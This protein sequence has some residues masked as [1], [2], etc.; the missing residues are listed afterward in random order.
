MDYTAKQREYIRLNILPRQRQ[1]SAAQNK[2]VDGPDPTEEELEEF[3]LV[4]EEYGLN[5]IRRQIYASRRDGK[6]VIAPT[7]DGL[8]WLAAQGGEWGGQD[9]PR[10]GPVDNR[11]IPECCEVTVYRKG[12][13]H[14]TTAVLYWSEYA[15]EKPTI[16]Q[17]SM[18]RIM[19][20]KA[21]ES[22]ALRRM[23]PEAL[24]GLVSME[25]MGGQDPGDDLSTPPWEMDGSEPT[26]VR[27]PELP[28]VNRQQAQAAAAGQTG[29]KPGL[30]TAPAG[31]ASGSRTGET[32]PPSGSQ[33]TQAGSS[34]DEG[35]QGATTPS[36]PSQPP[37]NALWVFQDEKGDLDALSK[38][39]KVQVVEIKRSDG[40]MATIEVTANGRKTS[41]A[42]GPRQSGRLMVLQPG[43]DLWIRVKKGE[44]GTSIGA[45]HVPGHV[46]QGK[47]AG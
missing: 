43:A 2:Y 45:Y 11:G 42:F 28:K 7:I 36:E 31:Q 32:P 38:P 30:S 44:D 16:T 46:V 33:A 10:F 12:C 19:L 26:T 20:A 29:S 27:R 34:K 21:T 23:Y 1:W 25:E 37:E 15:G 47:R 3:L 5:P 24:G 14:G 13:E 39:V 9:A 4:A 17:R 41:G 8:R 22:Q 6:L 40:G 18:P 35:A